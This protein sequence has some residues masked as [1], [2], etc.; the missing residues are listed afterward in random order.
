MHVPPAILRLFVINL[1]GKESSASMMT[2]TGEKS[3]ENVFGEGLVVKQDSTSDI[4]NYF[5]FTEMT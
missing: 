1:V 5:G 2:E 3:E 4:W